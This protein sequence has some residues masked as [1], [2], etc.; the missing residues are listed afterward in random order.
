M[1]FSNLVTTGMYGDDLA[2][3]KAL[4]TL[5]SDLN[6]ARRTEL[7]VGDDMSRKVTKDYNEALD[8]VIMGKELTSF[9]DTAMELNAEGQVTGVKSLFK[10]A[11]LKTFNA[12][13]VSTEILGMSEEEAMAALGGR[14][15]YNDTMQVVANNM[16]KTLLGE[17]SKNVSN[18]DRE[19]AQEISGLVRSLQAGAFQNPQLLNDKLQRVRQRINMNIS[20]GEA[21]INQLSKQYENRLVT[22]TDEK[23]TSFV[24]DPLRKDATATKGTTY[25]NI[26][27]DSGVLGEFITND[28]GSFTYK[29]FEAEK[30]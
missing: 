25:R 14:T 16:L 5:Q 8:K 28:D 22:G 3:V 30:K 2:A 9:I 21:T 6:K 20:Q 17:G 29:M 7:V 12:A 10:D 13:G 24:L 23:F 26:G 11:V 27:S 1:D 15:K 18:I 19:L 4:N